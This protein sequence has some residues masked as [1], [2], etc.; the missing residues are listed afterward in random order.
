MN[1]LLKISMEKLLERTDSDITDITQSITEAYSIAGGLDD[2]NIKDAILVN[3]EQAFTSI[4]DWQKYYHHFNEI[5]V[6][7]SSD[8]SKLKDA[9]DKLTKKVEEQ[10]VLIS[11]LQTELSVANELINQKNNSSNMV[12]VDLVEMIN[13][14]EAAINII[15]DNASKIVN[16]ERIKRGNFTPA[17]RIDVSDDVIKDLY[18]N[19]ETPNAIAK[20]FGMTQPAIIYRLKQMGIYVEGGRK[21][22]KN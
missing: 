18:L 11:Q 9:N 13:T 16:S 12:Q 1:N 17:K 8:S 15:N 2:S 20:R 3:L 22:I 14:L 19:N 21:N 7:I 4:S 5:V 10:S 6:N